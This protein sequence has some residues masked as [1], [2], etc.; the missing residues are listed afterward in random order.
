[1]QSMSTIIK[2][3][4]NFYL[5]KLFSF[6]K[7]DNTR[8]AKKPRRKFT[9]GRAK[10]IR[11]T[12]ENL[13][14]NFKELSRATSKHSWDDVVNIKGLKK[15]GVFVPPNEMKMGD[16]VNSNVCVPEKFPSIMFVA[17]NN[18]W[19]ADQDLTTPNFF[20][21][22]KYKT[23]PYYV[24]PT[25]D[26]VYKIGVSIPASKNTKTK[27][28][29]F[30]LYYFIAVDKEGKVRTLRW[31]NDQLVNIPHK[32]G[33]TTHY[34]RKSWEHPNLFPDSAMAK[35]V[36]DRELMHIGVFCACF[37]F[38]TKRDKMWT[39]QTQ[40]D[41]MRMSFCVDT[42]DTKHYFK[43]REYVTTLQGHRK[44]IIH[45]VETHTRMTPT[46]ESMVREHIRGERKFIWNGYQCTVK[47]PQFKNIISLVD[48]DT[49]AIEAAAD[50]P[51]WK[52][53]R[54]ALGLA[55]QLTPLLDAEQDNIYSNKSFPQFK[56]GK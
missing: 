4:V 29:N 2:A 24:E 15:L 42:K 11:Q 54:D 35:E 49:P 52:T 13:D 31:V 26:I 27:R 45:F 7:R 33:R 19:P 9:K 16:L 37:N 30:W 17:T 12:L 22:F 28:N 18:F 51:L 50:D 21:A 56:E 40:K 23:T 6:F 38:W 5:Q 34:T 47:A 36:D 44:K 8:P 25:K 53:S 32:T 43:D 1:M 46:G 39:V 48:L 55:K 41:N 14:Q 3:Q 20:Y 10:T